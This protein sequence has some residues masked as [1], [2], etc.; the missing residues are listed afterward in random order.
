MTGTKLVI[1]KDDKQGK[2]NIAFSAE[3]YINGAK[4]TNNGF[5][6][7]APPAE[8]YLKTLSAWPPE[9]WADVR[10]A[11]M[12]YLD[13]KHTPLSRS[14]SRSASEALAE[15]P[16][17]KYSIIQDDYYLDDDRMSDDEGSVTFDVPRRELNLPEES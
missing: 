10:A 6:L 14:V 12:E 17:P 15:E 4:L 16:K 8:A 3:N 7:N 2:K 11:A 13:S 5:K 9:R 1:D